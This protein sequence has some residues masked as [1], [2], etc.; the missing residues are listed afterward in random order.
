MAQINRYQIE[1]KAGLVQVMG[2]TRQ[3]KKERRK[4]K[5]MGPTAKLN[6]KL[7]LGPIQ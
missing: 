4:K 3:E 6:R 2:P 5:K 7:N 1:E